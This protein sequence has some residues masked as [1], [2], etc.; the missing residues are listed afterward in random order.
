MLGA[1]KPLEKLARGGNSVSWCIQC[2]GDNNHG[3]SQWLFYASVSQATL[4]ADEAAVQTCSKT[5]PQSKGSPC[6][7]LVN[8]RALGSV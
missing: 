2:P 3:I 8:I 4:W 1:Q 7:A 5:S 6:S